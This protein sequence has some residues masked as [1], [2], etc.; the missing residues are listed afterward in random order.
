MVVAS[1]ILAFPVVGS[2]LFLMMMP[3]PGQQTGPKRFD[4]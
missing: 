4:G 2:L 1:A 3:K